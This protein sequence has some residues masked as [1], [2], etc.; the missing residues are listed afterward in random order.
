MVRFLLDRGI[1][2]NA[3]ERYGKA[4][5]H[6]ASIEGHT[7][8]VEILLNRGA[9]PNDLDSRYSNTPLYYAFK[10]RRDEVVKCLIC[11]DARIKRSFLDQH[12]IDGIGTS[13]D[14]SRTLTLWQFTMGVVCLGELGVYYILD[15]SSIIDLYQYSVDLK[16]GLGLGLGFERDR[17]AETRAGFSAEEEGEEVVVVEEEFLCR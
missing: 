3:K 2:V 4:S 16:L 15:A 12:W 17:G 7:S 11:K 8:V 9:D 10:N 6:L 1:E 14:I 13:A 5:I